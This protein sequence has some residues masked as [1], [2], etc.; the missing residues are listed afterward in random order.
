MNE[1]TRI[2]HNDKCN[3]FLI[4]S[5]LAQHVDQIRTLYEYKPLAFN[6]SFV[7]IGPV[8]KNIQEYKIHFSNM[9]KY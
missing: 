5:L 8:E 6:A 2:L 4:L 9:E 1:M 7:F 3:N